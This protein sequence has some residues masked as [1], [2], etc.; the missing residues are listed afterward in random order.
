M[1]R[2]GGARRSKRYAFSKN[3]KAKGKISLNNYLREF[4]AGDKVNL[5]IEPAINSGQYHP[6]FIG[7]AGV[8]SGKQGD[9]YLVKINDFDKEKTLVV[10]PIH[11]RKA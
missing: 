9:C 8:V 2:K 5:T 11:M 6:R 1:A 3:I 4:Q 10:H 7:K